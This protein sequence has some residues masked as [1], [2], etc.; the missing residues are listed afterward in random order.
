MA[1]NLA[2]RLVPMR[3]SAAMSTAA[4]RAAIR[5][6][7]MAVAPD[8]S[9]RKRV[10][11]LDILVSLLASSHWRASSCSPARPVDGPPGG[12]FEQLAPR[13]RTSRRVELGADGREGLVQVG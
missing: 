5:P 12:P 13:L 6:Y 2:S 4:I 1:L 7:S 11:N 9:F 3:V 8:S 10:T